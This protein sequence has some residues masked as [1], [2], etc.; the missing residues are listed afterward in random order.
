VRAA[1]GGEDLPEQEP[2]PFGVHAGHRVIGADEVGRP[3][4]GC[5]LPPGPDHDGRTRPDPQ[6]SQLAATALRHQAD[7]LRA[8]HR[9][10][11]HAGVHDRRLDRPVRPQRR[12]DAQA[13][14]AR[15]EPE[16]FL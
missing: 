2:Q 13:V 1:R 12:H 6:V 4:G 3:F 11:E 14:V 8:C 5:P 16:E 7:Y 9:M 15:D 10:T